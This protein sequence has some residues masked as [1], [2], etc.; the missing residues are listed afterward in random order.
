[1]WLSRKIFCMILAITFLS[2]CGFK[3][4]LDNKENRS[5]VLGIGKFNIF[6]PKDEISFKIR[7][8][9]LKDLGLPEQ[10]SHMIL[11]DSKLK[12][13]KS[14]I[15]K[16]NEITRYNL[17]LESKF[18]LISLQIKKEI[19]NKN[20]IS[21][22]AYSAS[23]NITG[24]ATKTAENSAEERLAKDIANKIIMELLMLRKDLKN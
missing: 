5:V 9:L 8:E 22:T 1:M 15:T 2:S 20:F 24:F 23:K 19:Y 4:L 11:V 7:E 14:L 12:R 17:I 10:P 21:Q 13:E 6:S 16:A 3:P 18:Q